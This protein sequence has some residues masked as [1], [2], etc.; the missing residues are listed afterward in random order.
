MGKKGI[1]NS[2]NLDA[3]DMVNINLEAL[4]LLMKELLA[5]LSSIQS[6]EEKSLDVNT[7]FETLKASRA[8]VEECIHTMGNRVYRKVEDNT[9]SNIQVY[10]ICK[11][12]REL[13]ENIPSAGPTIKPRRLKKLV[14]ILLSI[15]LF[16]SMSLTCFL[17]VENMSLRKANTALEEAS[18]KDMLLKDIVHSQ[19]DKCAH[20]SDY[21]DSLYA[22]KDVHKE[23]IEELWRVYLNRRKEEKEKKKEK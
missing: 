12:I 11:E 7:F 2:Q 20:W 21:L 5:K 19:H 8:E 22:Q 18:R 14:P 17:T 16:L 4:M 1:L 9:A 3:T 23:Q 15:S 13:V 10:K 6:R